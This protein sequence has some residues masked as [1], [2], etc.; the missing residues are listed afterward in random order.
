MARDVMYSGNQHILFIARSSGVF[1]D[2]TKEWRENISL[3]TEVPEALEEGLGWMRVEEEVQEVK[4]NEFM[5]MGYNH[6]WSGSQQ[7]LLW[8]LQ[9]KHKKKYYLIMIP[10]L[11]SYGESSHSS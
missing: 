5:R 4:K 2:E 3:G 8:N 7:K 1:C 11:S 6:L 9:I 10:G